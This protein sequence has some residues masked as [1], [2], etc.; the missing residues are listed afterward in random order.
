MT[1]QE[2]TPEA[3]TWTLLPGAQFADAFRLALPPSAGMDAPTAARRMM[4]TSPAWVSGLVA[5]RNA[6]VAPLGLKAPQPADDDDDDADRIGI[7]PVISSGPDR[8]VLGMAD[9]HLDFRAVVDVRQD[10]A[11]WQVT[12]T[13]VVRTH[14]WLGRFYLAVIMPFHRLV[15][16]AMLAQVRQPQ[17]NGI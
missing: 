12:A 7:F 10:S 16:R 14:N 1:I 15:V 4:A 13:T 2:V 6:L 8:V 5:L 9:K 17:S 11:S 3:G